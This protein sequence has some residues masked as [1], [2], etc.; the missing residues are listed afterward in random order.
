MTEPNY[1][2]MSADELREVL[3]Q[4][5][6]ERLTLRDKARAIADL[7]RR[8]SAEEHAAYYGLTPHQYNEAKRIASE[9]GDSFAKVLGGARKKRSVQVARALAAGVGTTS[10]DVRGNQ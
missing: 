10:Q 8:R 3:D 6:V 2:T 9:S 4:L 5:D 1:E 7:H